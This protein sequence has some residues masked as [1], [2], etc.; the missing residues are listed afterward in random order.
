F[1]DAGLAWRRCS[2]HK[3]LDDADLWL[4]STSPEYDSMTRDMLFSPKQY[5]SDQFS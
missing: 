5:D 3:Q 1:D 4:C 2:W